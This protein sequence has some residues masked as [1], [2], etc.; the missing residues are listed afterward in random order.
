MQAHPQKFSD[1][2]VKPPVTLCHVPPKPQNPRFISIQRKAKAVTL[3]SVICTQEWNK[4]Q[5]LAHRPKNSS[6]FLRCVPGLSIPSPNG[7]RSRRGSGPLPR[8][9]DPISRSYSA[10]PRR[11]APPIRLDSPLTCGKCLCKVVPAFDGGDGGVGG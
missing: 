9:G 3:I 1:I 8:G 10:R 11:L 4:S 2:E 5:A 7:P 6:F